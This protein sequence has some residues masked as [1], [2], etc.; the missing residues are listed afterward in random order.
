MTF[1]DDSD[2]PI[3]PVEIDHHVDEIW[4]DKRGGDLEQIYNFLDYHFER[5][6]AYMRARAYLDEASAVTTY[7]PVSSRGSLEA[8]VAPDFERDVKAYLAR[9]FRHVKRC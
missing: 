8:R 2:D 4:A 9:R 1:V 7:G 6:G 3:I 5:D